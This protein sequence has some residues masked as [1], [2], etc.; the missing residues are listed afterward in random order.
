MWL[1][2][3]GAVDK[4]V[5]STA[6]HVAVAQE[7]LECCE[8]LLNSGADVD[9]K[10]FAGSTCMHVAAEAGSKEVVQLLMEFQ[11]SLNIRNQE[12]RCA[13]ALANNAAVRQLIYNEVKR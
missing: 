8:V 1:C 3:Q 9:E 5:L 2:L 4:K 12:G 13:I 6:L 10:N 7:N 11:A